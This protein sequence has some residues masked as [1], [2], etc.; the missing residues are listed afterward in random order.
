M[1]RIILTDDEQATRDLVA[2]ALLIDGHTVAVM[3]SASEALEHMRQSKGGFDVLVTDVDMPGMDGF[4]L[5]THALALQPQLAV[6][7]MSGFIDQLNRAK[8]L[9]T[10]RSVTVAKPFSLEDIRSKVRDA[11]LL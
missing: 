9:G 5:A 6:V 7:M 8:E 1:A 11:M 3:A 10:K 4:E 2:R